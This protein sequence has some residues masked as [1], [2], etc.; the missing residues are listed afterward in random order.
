[1]SI[2]LSFFRMRLRVSLG[3]PG[4][5]RRFSSPS[6]HRHTGSA[7]PTRTRE[8]RGQCRV[9]GACRC[10]TRHS[11][12]D[13]PSLRKPGVSGWEIRY[14]AVPLAGSVVLWLGSDHLWGL[15]GSSRAPGRRRAASH[16]LPTPSGALGRGE[17][18][19][20]K[21]ACLPAS[22]PTL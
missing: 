10:K 17:L 4:A 11:S 2:I 22:S 20:P 14:L 8:Q 13:R 6:H 9:W 21:L 16:E 12:S 15:Q 19:L 5:P 1:M 7:W 18:S 3:S